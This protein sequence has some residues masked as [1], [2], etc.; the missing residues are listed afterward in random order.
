MP[1]DLHEQ[2]VKYI[3]ALAE[4][5]GLKTIPVRFIRQN[6]LKLPDLIC[7]ASLDDCRDEAQ[8][9]TV[10]VGSL[11]Q[12]NLE[13]F[14][15]TLMLWV[16]KEAGNLVNGMWVH[17][18]QVD[19]ADLP[20]ALLIALAFLK[21][22]R[23][24]YTAKA[25]EQSRAMGIKV[26]RERAVAAMGEADRHCEALACL[27]YIAKAFDAGDYEYLKD[28]LP[29]H[30]K[31]NF[32]RLLGCDDGMP[33]LYGYLAHLHDV[34]TDEID[35]AVDHILDA[36]GEIENLYP[37]LIP[38]TI[39]PERMRETYELLARNIPPAVDAVVSGFDVLTPPTT[40]TN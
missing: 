24:P 22:E 6:G 40:P 2:K 29:D 12:Q 35:G 30:L 33:L 9:L 4:K 13:V 25:I 31:K 34:L 8:W 7:A 20:E 23:I 15:H 17:N 32:A 10:E 14:K 16:P 38:P 21:H 36:M 19:V 5:C 26:A 27:G 1:S 28:L 37:G 11:S 39:D 3:Q 18:R